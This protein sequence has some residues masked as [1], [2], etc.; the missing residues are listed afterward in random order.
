MQV[1]LQLDQFL[2]FFLWISRI[3]TSL[4]R[5]Y[6]F[7]LPFIGGFFSAVGNFT[8]DEIHHIVPGF[9]PVK[10][11]STLLRGRGFFCFFLWHYSEN[12]RTRAAFS[13]VETL[14]YVIVVYK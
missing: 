5:A 11:N 4:P 1:L 14:R 3:L 13:K 10:L 2:N 6:D 9:N 7:Q 12:D 8:A